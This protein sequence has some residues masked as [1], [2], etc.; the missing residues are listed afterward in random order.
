M[1]AL[2]PQLRK[3]ILAFLLLTPWFSLYLKVI[4]PHLAQ[5]GFD[6][7]VI[8]LV[9]LIFVIFISIFGR[10]P[11]ITK[12]GLFLLIAIAGWHLS[13]FISAYLS[14]H[15]YPSIIKQIEY[16]IHC[17]FA[18]SA[19]VFLSQT[20]KQEKMAWFL[21]FTFVWI[22]YYIYSAWFISNEPYSVDWVTSTP[23]FNNIRHSGFIFISILPLLFLPALLNIKHKTLLT[24]CLLS[25]YW[26]V[27][28]WTCSRGSYFASII[29]IAIIYTL[30]KNT[31]RL[32]FIIL[33][34]F[35]I[36]WIIALQFPSTSES[37]N[38][39]RLWFLNF[40]S[41]EADTA[42]TLSSGR[43]GIW[44]KSYENAMN[45]NF[46]FGYGANGYAYISPIILTNTVH[47]HSSLF[48]LL[49][50]YGYIGFTLIILILINILL[51]WENNKT[52]LSPVNVL[53]RCSVIGFIIGSAV[54]G[55]FYYNFSLLYFSII[56]A[57][58]IPQYKKSPKNNKAIPIG[59]LLIAIISIYPIKEHW[60]TYIEQQVELIDIKQIEQ[61]EK[62]PSYYYPVKWLYG[63]YTNK[64]LQE[65]SIKLGQTIGPM[66]CNFYLLEYKNNKNNKN[67]K[68]KELKNRIEKYCRKQDLD[69]FN[70]TD[71][72]GIL[73]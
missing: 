26:A 9:E 32:N 35:L 60:S 31:P 40:N 14:D 21:V 63:E 8:T 42:N 12:Q 11:K 28:I 36:G 73:K 25:L 57:L 50:E 70:I 24:V 61:V 72:K 68:N 43:V 45:H 38:P 39:F 27:L 5:T 46:L 17:M 34:S 47:P 16:L 56:L 65:K 53:S 13:G 49:G 66:Y 67:N 48:Q 69:N 23:F 2:S 29:I 15:F 1:V 64:D 33:S 20:Q 18:Y 19:W 71:F 51:A 4:F 41:I 10:H 6:G 7:S 52:S 22:V 62:F 59:I 44:F 54:D 37:L 58:S 30:Y 55:H 3:I